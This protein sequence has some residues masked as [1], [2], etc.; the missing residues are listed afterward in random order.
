MIQENTR[1]HHLDQSEVGDLPG[2][3]PSAVD[4]GEKK[5]LRR[6]PPH[7]AHQHVIPAP[8]PDVVVRRGGQTAS[9]THLMTQWGAGGLRLGQSTGVSPGFRC[10]WQVIGGFLGM[11]KELFVALSTGERF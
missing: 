8:S 4:E 1:Q 3:L 11:T 7:S 6:Q 9:C 5:Q 10:R 2:V